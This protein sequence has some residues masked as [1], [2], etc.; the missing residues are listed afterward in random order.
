M[1]HMTAP[2]IGMPLAGSLGARKGRLTFARPKGRVDL[3]VVDDA[4]GDEDLLNG[5]AAAKLA[6]VPR[7]TL[8]RAS[9]DDLP[10]VETGGTPRR[11][12]QRRYRKSDVE[13][14][15]DNRTRTVGGR[16]TAVEDGL[17]ETRAELDRTRAELD[18]LKQWRERHDPPRT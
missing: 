9:P 14:Y 2:A 11:G 6:G 16:L 1:R 12:G 17:A 8:W 18:E 4:T 15:R 13:R 7:T 5:D 10:Y 3:S